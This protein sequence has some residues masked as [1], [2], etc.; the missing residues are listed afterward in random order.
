[1]EKLAAIH[2]LQL[3][4]CKPM[5]YDSFYISMLSSKYKHGKTSLPGSFYQ[6]LTSNWKALLQ[7][8]KCSSL[9]YVLGK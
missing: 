5:W 6:G 7:I 8:R 1:M 9:I 2:G 3:I 4:S